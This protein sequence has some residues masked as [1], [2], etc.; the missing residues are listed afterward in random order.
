MS[1]WR[2]CAC[3]WTILPYSRA[4]PAAGTQPAS[5][6]TAPRPPISLELVVLAQALGDGEVVDLAIV[7][8]ELEHRAVDRAVL[9]AIEVLG[10]QLL[11][12]DQP[13]QVPLVEQHRAEHRALGV[14]VVRW[15]RH[16][17]G[18]GAGG[19]AVGGG[20]GVLDGA[21]GAGE[22]R[23]AFTGELTII[24]LSADVSRAAVS[25]P[26]ER[27]PAGRPTPRSGLG[28]PQRH[29]RPDRAER[30]GRR[31]RPDRERPSRGWCG[32]AYLKC[33]EVA[34]CFGSTPNRNAVVDVN[35]CPAG[36]TTV[37]HAGSS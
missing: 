34:Y 35:V 29:D 8:V 14:E 21:H 32:E 23:F 28:R 3:S 12:D 18:R 10:S 19:A 5:S 4:C 30:P 15:Q 33:T 25:A 17:R 22:S 7:A 13:V 36:S 27:P 2:S 16:L 37:G 26:D 24:P 9:L 20:G 31:T 1:S 6:S 11:L